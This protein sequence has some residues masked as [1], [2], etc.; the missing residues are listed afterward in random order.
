MTVLSLS[1]LWVRRRLHID[2]NNVVLID[3][4]YLAFHCRYA[5]KDLSTV[6]QKTGLIFNYI[7]NI[8]KLAKRFRTNKFV[9]AF[10]SSKSLRKEIYPNYKNRPSNEEDE[11]LNK[12]CKQQVLELRKY[13]LP[14]IGFKNVFYVNGYES[15]D[16]IGDLVCQNNS[17]YIVIGRD[18]DYYQLLNK[19]SMWDVKKKELRDESWLIKEKGVDACQYLD[20][21]CLAGCSTDIVAGINRVGEPTAIKYILGTLGNHTKAY[22]DIESE[23]GKEI[24]QRNKK[25]IQLPFE[26]LNLQIVENEHFDRVRFV[27]IMNE[28]NMFSIVRDDL[29]DWVKIFNMKDG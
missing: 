19:C 16:I 3:N 23:N 22:K 2:M 17:K 20:A 18:H 11:V 5:I 7:T 29:D 6:E 25:L 4:G 1:L 10:D 24:A 15:D 12:L 28:D 21:C 9:F 26:K 27:E 8:L 14:E 13:I